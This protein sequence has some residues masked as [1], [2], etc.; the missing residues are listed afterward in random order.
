MYFAYIIKEFNIKT[1]DIYPDNGREGLLNQLGSQEMLNY[2]IDNKLIDCNERDPLEGST[3]L[4]F[5]ATKGATEIVQKLID[6]KVDLN[7]KTRKGKTALDLVMLFNE[8]SD[9]EV[10]LD[11]VQGVAK[12][13]IDAGADQN[14]EIVKPNK[15]EKYLKLCRNNDK[16]KAREKI[17]DLD[18]INHKS[19][20]DGCTALHLITESDRQ[21]DFANELI[22]KGADLNIT[23]DDGRTPLIS[24][25]Q[26][27]NKAQA[28]NLIEK[29]AN[30][31]IEADPDIGTALTLCCRN[32]MDEVAIK[33]IQMGA[34][35][36]YMDSQKQ[37]LLDIIVRNY[38]SEMFER[39]QKVFDLLIQK[40]AKTD[41]TTFCGGNL[42]SVANKDYKKYIIKNK[43]CDLNAT[44][45]DEQHTAL[46][47]ACQE[48][49]L[50][51]VDDLI[52]AGIDP[53]IKNKDGKTAC[54]LAK[55]RY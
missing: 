54:D 31:N 51:L 8:D 36:N 16:N 24:A 2:L 13:L 12:L 5:V 34:D 19:V 25:C 35:I 33:L 49:D 14:Q 15:S 53:N 21:V 32:S 27:G 3:I 20:K 29:G 55:E 17:D 4:H 44:F 11:N 37:P 43:L 28:M 9:S 30:I 26:F 38:S 42:Y 48:Y 7:A 47:L 41:F 52:M 6:V 45:E 40:G 50:G 22:A 1:I 10:E 18:N 39:M 23:D 46:H